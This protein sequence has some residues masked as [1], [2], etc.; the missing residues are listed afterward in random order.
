MAARKKASRKKKATSK[1]KVPRATKSR[2]S[3]KGK[4][5]G[6]RR[7]VFGKRALKALVQLAGAGNTIDDAARLLCVSKSTLERAIAKE[8]SK[9]SEAWLAG[10]AH[11]RN[12]LRVA[13]LDLALGGN[14]T[15]QIWLGK[16][17]L[18]QRNYQAIEVTGAGGGP[19]EISD[20]GEWLDLLGAQIRA[21][22]RSRRKVE[23]DLP[24]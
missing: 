15:M 8:G 24:D 5:G 21:L 2:A 19:L 9:A 12:T 4:G 22:K 20:S 17:E 18:G 10:K 7:F 1:A 3:R 11:M 14:A 6:P 16:Q 23:L 13:Q